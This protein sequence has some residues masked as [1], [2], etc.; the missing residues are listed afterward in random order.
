METETDDKP[1]LVVTEDDEYGMG[2][3]KFT[4]TV[5]DMVTLSKRT[6]Q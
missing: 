1:I 5:P 6:Q 2:E 4:S 3:T